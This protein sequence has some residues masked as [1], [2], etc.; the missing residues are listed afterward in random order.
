MIIAYFGFLISMNHLL[1]QMFTFCF[2]MKY[3]GSLVFE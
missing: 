1:Y 3:I 2:I